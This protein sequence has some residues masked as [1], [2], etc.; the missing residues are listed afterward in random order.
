MKRFFN[1]GLMSALLI[2]ISLAAMAQ[3]TI[4]AANFPNLSTKYTIVELDSV[5]LE[6]GPAGANMTWDMSKYK[7][8]GET[9]TLEFAT[10]SS[11]LY[12]SEFPKANIAQ[13]SDSAATYYLIDGND[14]IRLGV[15]YAGGREKLTDT[16]LMLK[17]PF[18]Y[19]DSFSDTFAG[20]ITH[21]GGTTNRS[22]TLTATAD[23]YGTLIT[24]NGTYTNVLRIKF[25]QKITDVTQGFETKTNVTSYSWFDTKTRYSIANI[26]YL[27][28]IVEV[29]GQ[30]F[31]TSTKS[32]DIVGEGPSTKPNKPGSLLPADGATGQTLPLTLSWQWDETEM[33]EK[34]KSISD[35][36]Q[37]EVTFTVQVAKDEDFSNIVIDESTSEMSY[38]IDE[39]DG[40]GPFFWRVEAVTSESSGW[41]ET[42]EFSLAEEGALD[43]PMLITPE[44]EATDIAL[45]YGFYWSDVEGADSYEIHVSDDGNFN[46]FVVSE[47]VT[48]NSLQT[49]QLQL[50]T[51]YYW[52]V[53]AIKD[54]EKS[55]WSAVYSF[56]TEGGIKAPEL[57]TPEDGATDVL[58]VTDFTW[59]EVDGTDAYELRVAKEP[60]YETL[61]ISETTEDTSFSSTNLDENTTYYWSV[62][63]K[64]GEN[65]S[66]WSPTFTFT[67]DLFIS[68][69][70]LSQAGIKIYPNP[71]TSKLN[72]DLPSVAS[73]LSARIFSANGN[74]VKVAKF[75]NTASSSI[76]VSALS[77][78]T[79]IIELKLDGTAVSGKFIVQ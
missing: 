26:S 13:K 72:I 35:R 38:T 78:G 22:G 56:T 34:G 15:G 44:D 64:M 8:N 59:G 24:P 33:V 29:M 55:D 4:T 40:V 39:L 25:E 66:D 12:G 63:S 30:Q 43:A 58:T 7:P 62:R 71:V 49:D 17:V 60:A 19:G 45:D 37:A 36:T 16:E 5:G 41:S 46:S 50:A 18:T 14:W 54:D 6:E 11:T 20:T 79:Y 48:D 2:I 21:E 3:P 23:G 53:R 52:Y 57:Y 73:N 74:L 67:T 76:D 70:E 65:Y 1:L 27:E 32:G 10:P 77:V 28:N 51:T 9:F 61:V 47:I 42:N 69:K 68:V 75:A 31:V